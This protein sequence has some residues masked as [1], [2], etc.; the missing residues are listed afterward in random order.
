MHRYIL[1]QIA[2][3]PNATWA[4]VFAKAMLF[5]PD[6]KDKDLVALSRTETIIIDQSQE[7]VTFT[8]QFID[9]EKLFSESLHNFLILASDVNYLLYPTNNICYY[10]YHFISSRE[11][12]C[13]DT[14]II[15]DNTIRKYK[16]SCINGQGRYHRIENYIKLT[17]KLYFNQMLV[18]MHNNYLG[19]DRLV[20]IG[21][22][23]DIDKNILDE[24]N[25]I[26]ENL[27]TNH[28]CTFEIYDESF[29]N[30]YINF[31]TETTVSNTVTF[32]SEKTF[33]AF[34]SGQLP[35]WLGS[36][37]TVKYIRDLGFD[38]FDDIINHSYDQEPNWH[39]RIDIIHQEIDRLINL[40]LDLVWK[41]TIN[42][43]LKN[44]QWLLSEELLHKATAHIDEHIFKRSN[45]S[46]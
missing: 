24:F 41:E 9:T 26:K 32:I 44:R 35:I 3:Y 10:P 8:Q 33:K 38:V 19:P 30:S 45:T 5:T 25:L 39:T 20:F 4:K 2:K 36:P 13:Q 43:R 6:P 18:R 17:K 16:I 37:N 23:S 15:S 27:P 11:L 12:A 40:D 29:C 31:I 22:T 42:R 7:P 28:H 46:P 1:T 34:R 21:N 14:D